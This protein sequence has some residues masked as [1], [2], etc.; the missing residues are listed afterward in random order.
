MISSHQLARDDRE[1]RGPPLHDDGHQL[2]RTALDPVPVEVQDV[3][4]PG[5]GPEDG[6]GNHARSQPVHPELGP[7]D[8]PEIPPASAHAPEQVRVLVLAGRDEPAIGRHHVDRREA[9]DDQAVLPHDPADHAAA[10]EAGQ[11]G[12]GHDPRR[13][14]IAEHL[15]LMVQ[16]AE[17]DAGLGPNPFPGGIDANAPHETEIDDH[18]T[19]AD[20][21]PR[22]SCGLRCVQRR[23]GRARQRITQQPSHRTRRRTG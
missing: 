2:V 21:E 1:V 13:D 9:V 8:D 18:A 22:G 20:G 16:L 12:V 17:E 19:V 4:R 7:G 23:E 6:A 3:T 5:H 11:A 15:R 10:G 14:R